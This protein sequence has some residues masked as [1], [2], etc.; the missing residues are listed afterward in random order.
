[1]SWSGAERSAVIIGV[2]AGAAFIAI[3]VGIVR[4]W[5]GGSSHDRHS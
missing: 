5:T 2:I 3:A 1:M 4:S